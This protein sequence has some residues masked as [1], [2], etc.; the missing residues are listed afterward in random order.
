MTLDYTTRESVIGTVVTL[1]HVR[2][3]D[4]LKRE[5]MATD[6]IVVIKPEHMPAFEQDFAIYRQLDEAQ[7]A[8]FLARL[9]QAS[10]YTGGWLSPAMLPQAQTGTLDLFSTEC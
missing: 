10:R 6:L 3:S 9:S 1:R 8:A 5:F 4:F 7:R 2:Y